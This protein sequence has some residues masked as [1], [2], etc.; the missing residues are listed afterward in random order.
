MRKIENIIFDLGGVILDID[1]N[2]TRAAFEK[3]GI[4]HFDEMYSQ[5]SADKLFQKLETGSISEEIFFKELNKCV[6]IQLSPVEIT[7][8]WNLMLLQFRETSLGFLEDIKPRYNLYLFS[9]TNYIHMAAFEKIFHEKFRIQPFNEYFKHAFY[10]CDIGLRKPD[11]ESYQWIIAH[12]KISPE[13]TLFIDDTVQNVEA[14]KRVGMQ[15]ILLNPG[16]KIEDLG[17]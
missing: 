2:L 17:L 3:L 8:A 10:S 1:Y 7:T 14:A 13:K 12:L 11:M 6:G 5:A 16:K 4:V 15:A 9:N